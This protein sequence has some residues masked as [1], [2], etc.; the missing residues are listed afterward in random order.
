MRTP[1]DDELASQLPSASSWN[2]AVHGL[3]AGV[4]MFIAIGLAAWISNAC[5][6]PALYQRTRERL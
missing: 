6:E 4:G 3:V 2:V 5:A 1:R